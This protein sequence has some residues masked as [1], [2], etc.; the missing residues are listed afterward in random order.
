M[1]RSMQDMLL[2]ATWW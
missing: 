1:R 2:D